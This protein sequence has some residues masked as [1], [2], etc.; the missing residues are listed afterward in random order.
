MFLKSTIT[1]MDG[2]KRDCTVISLANAF[3]KSYEEVHAYLKK[4]GRINGQSYQSSIVLD[5][6]KSIRGKFKAKIA[7][8]PELTRL[9]KNSH[10]YKPYRQTLKVFIRENQVG[11][12]LI[13]ISRHLTCIKDGNIVDTHMPGECSKVK[14]AWKVD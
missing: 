13:R 9:R 3:N 5:K 14:I 11:T 6:T 12:Y 8:V 4:N 2:E 7:R 10:A 1:P